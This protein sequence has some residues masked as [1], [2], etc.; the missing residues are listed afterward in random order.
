MATDEARLGVKHTARHDA[1]Q[2]VYP[3]V[4]DDDEFFAHTLAFIDPATGEAEPANDVGDNST[5]IVAAV[6]RFQDDDR[7]AGGL[8][9]VGSADEGRVK[10][11]H[12]YFVELELEE[13]L[14]TAN[15]G[16]TV[17]AVDNETVALDD[18]GGER[19]EAGWI[20]QVLEGKDSVFVRVPGLL[21]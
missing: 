18:G 21:A 12:D 16:D 11:T 7:D 14:D 19:P 5:Q 13:D 1:F 2:V 10:L 9:R 3:L 6:G 8:Q 4:D 20:L 15:I 17:Y